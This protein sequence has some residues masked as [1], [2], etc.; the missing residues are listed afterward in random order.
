MADPRQ[1]KYLVRESYY[2]YMTHLQDNLLNTGYDW[3]SNLF[4]KSVSTYIIS[5][6]KRNNIVGQF[7]KL[8]VYMISQV[9]NIKKAVNYTVNKNYKYLN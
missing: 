4:S 8:M 2:Q 9:S 7:Q 1:G 3:R 5:D 6:P